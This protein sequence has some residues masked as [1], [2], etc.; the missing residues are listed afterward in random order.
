[1]KYETGFKV[2][3][4]LFISR[5]NDINPFFFRQRYL[6]SVAWCPL[7]QGIGRLCCDRRSH[8]RT[9]ALTTLQRALLYHDLQT[10]LTA[11]EWESAFTKVLFPMLSHLLFPSQPGLTLLVETIFLGIF[12]FDQCIFV[13]QDKT[14]FTN[15]ISNS[16]GATAIADYF[17]NLFYIRKDYEYYFKISLLHSSV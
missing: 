2:Y 3:P 7:L 1:M 14:P 11:R 16:I 17:L 6:W 13:Q 8:I 5:M 4:L 10:I 15:E 12:C 9:S